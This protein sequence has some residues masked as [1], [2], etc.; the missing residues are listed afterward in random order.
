MIL[1]LLL[2]LTPIFEMYLLIRLGGEFGAWPTIGVV[3]L[4]AVVGIA[5][6]RRQGPAAMQRVVQRMQSGAAPA[7]EL[8]EGALLALAGVLLLIPGFITDAVGLVLLVPACRRALAR[9]MLARHRP[10]NGAYGTGTMIIEGEFERRPA[11]PGASGR[12]PAPFDR[13][14]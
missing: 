5:L 3:L 6:L 8:A 11:E 12:D 1:L 9:R 2:F 14:P 4:T 10:G 7:Q 13:R